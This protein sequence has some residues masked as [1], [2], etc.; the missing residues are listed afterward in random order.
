MRRRRVA[1]SG[2]LYPSRRRPEG[3]ERIGLRKQRLAPLTS[4]QIGRRG[5]VGLVYLTRRVLQ[6]GVCGSDPSR[7]HD[8]A[9][10][11]RAYTRR[12]DPDPGGPRSYC[13]R[14][15][16]CCT[17]SAALGPH[18]E[19]FDPARSSWRNR[20]R[21]SGSHICLSWA[22]ACAYGGPV[23]ADRAILVLSGHCP[24]LPIE[25]ADTNPSC[26]SRLSPT[27]ARHPPLFPASPPAGNEANRASV[28][29]SSCFLQ[30]SYRRAR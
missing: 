28:L 16:G 9:P 21:T 18:P 30:G 26:R 4:V 23:R 8:C 19:K 14:P 15:P 6:E 17:A 22:R 13:D 2:A 27:Q 25:R 11:A 12:R 29:F 3:R 20:C 10:G 5:V 24:G 7:P 1:F